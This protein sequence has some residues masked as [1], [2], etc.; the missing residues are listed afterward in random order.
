MQF[1]RVLAALLLMSTAAQAQDDAWTGLYGGLGLDF[2]NVR[3]VPLAGGAATNEGNGLLV[4]AQG[5]YRYDLGDIVLGANAEVTFGGIEVPPVAG[6][7]PINP[8]LDMLAG[9]GIEAGYDLGDLLVYGGVGY[10]WATA[11]NAAGNR[12]YDSGSEFGIGADYML[13]DTM[14]VGGGVT[15]LNLNNFG[16]SDFRATSF[17]LRA[18]FRF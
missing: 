16:G 2:T 11:T 13:T 18:A 6:P 5:G 9:V 17:G 8:S 3:I 12:M 14:I 4:G 15:R 7:I 1:T 10:T